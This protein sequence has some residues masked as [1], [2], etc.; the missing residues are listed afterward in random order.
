MDVIFDIDGTLLYITH[1][2]HHLNLNESTPNSE[3]KG[4]KDWKAFRDPELK[5]LD[6]PRLPIL[7]TLL[8]LHAVGNRIIL[9]SG[10]IESE[11]EATVNSLRNAFDFEHFEVYSSSADTKTYPLKDRMLHIFDFH[12][13]PA[14][15]GITEFTPSTAAENLEIPFYMRADNDY[16]PDTE[17]KSDMLDQMHKDGYNPTMAFDDRPSVIR[18]WKERGLVVANVGPQ[19]EF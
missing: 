13:W 1:R 15:R 17:V 12:S 16:R 3:R 18:M 4:K 11:R 10:R 9:A 19:K 2:L 6:E 8:A 14:S 7:E 5:K